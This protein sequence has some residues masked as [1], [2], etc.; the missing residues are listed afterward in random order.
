MIPLESNFGDL[1]CLVATASGEHC[2]LA[3]EQAVLMISCKQTLTALTEV[4]GWKSILTSAPPISTKVE[5]HTAVL[6]DDIVALKIMIN[7]QDNREVKA[8]DNL[9][10]FQSSDE[11]FR[12]V[13]KDFMK[14]T[15]KKRKRHNHST[16]VMSYHVLVAVSEM[17]MANEHWDCLQILIRQNCLSARRVPMLIPALIERRNII[18]LKDCLKHLLDI[19]ESVCVSI[20]KF[21]LRECSCRTTLEVIKIVLR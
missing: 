4:V 5:V 16:S 19:P 3:Y 17:C 18:L 11:N 9:K 6:A 7:D 13:F 20:L 8:L 21:F 12:R 1:V 15:H 10:R 14:T 2:I